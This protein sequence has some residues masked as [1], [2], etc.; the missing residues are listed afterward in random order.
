MNDISGSRVVPALER[1]TH[2]VALWIERSLVDFQLTQAEAH[3]LAYLAEHPICS[4]NDL[5]HSFGHKRST[6][7]SLLDRLENRGWIQRDAHPSSRRLVQVKLT[8]S[9]RPIADRVGR[10]VRALESR[11]LSRAGADDVAAY[12]RVIQALEEETQ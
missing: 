2:A 8:D 3:V 12:L 9:G 10:E 4:I 1:A 5:H 7:T 6:L 11:V